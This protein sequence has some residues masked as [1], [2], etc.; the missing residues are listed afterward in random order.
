MRAATARASTFARPQKE[1]DTGARL[2]QLFEVLNT[3]EDRRQTTLDDDLKQLPYVNGDLFAE[4]LPIPAFNA[5]MRNRLLEACDFSWDAISPAIFGSLFQSVM[6]KKE[7]RAAGG[8]G[9]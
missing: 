9:G 3:P 1:S 7:R 5:E 4:R 8:H 6:N 2:S